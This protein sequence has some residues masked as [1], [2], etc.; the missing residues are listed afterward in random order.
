MQG[1]DKVPP[2]VLKSKMAAGD[3]ICQWT[4]TIFSGDT[5]RIL[6]ERQSFLKNPARGLGDVVT[7]K[8]LRTYGH[9]DARMDTRWSTFK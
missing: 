6:G 4:A 1:F 5:A 3:H 7:I 8:S 9:T 2:V